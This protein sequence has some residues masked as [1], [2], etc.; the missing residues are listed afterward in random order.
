MLTRSRSTPLALAALSLALPFASFGQRF[1]TAVIGG[2]GLTGDIE[3]S[4][5]AA[6]GVSYVSAPHRYLAGVE[7]EARLLAGFSVAADIVYRPLGYTFQLAGVMQSP[8]QNSVITWEVPILVRYR[9]PLGVAP[10]VAPFVEAG[11]AF[12]LAGNLNYTWPSKTGTAAGLG[13]EGD[14]SGWRI[15]PELR[16]IRWSPDS[17]GQPLL[18]QNDL[19]A[20]V[21]IG[22]PRGT[23]RWFR[24]GIS[25]GL[26]L[27]AT[28]TTDYP[29]VTDQ[30]PTNQNGQPTVETFIGAPGPRGVTGGPA[31]QLSL[32]RGLAL[33]ADAIERTWRGTTQEGAAS[34]V[35]T[36]YQTWELPLLARYKL[37][38]KESRR[39]QPFFEA[40][41]ALRTRGDLAAA[42]VARH[43]VTAGAGMEGR[44]GRVR[45]APM[46]RFTR[47]AQPEIQLPFPLNLNEVTALLGVS[48]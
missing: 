31:L 24:R 10:G 12:R 21:R 26:L 9:L 23:A 39:M 30:F 45:I 33:E 20:L 15:A 27:G 22:P 6:G 11:P 1:S 2:A 8:S 40:G 18:S 32:F 43:G 13:V 47:W 19:E 5:G 29:S 38:P 41:P 7:F 16:Y 14:I 36:S 37:G 28:L 34:A 44:L 17:S 3:N 35:S 25:I 48:F 4:G 42:E 46:V